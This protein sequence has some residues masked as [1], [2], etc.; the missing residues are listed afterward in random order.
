MG[1]AM[2]HYPLCAE[3]AEPIGWA[4]MQVIVPACAAVPCNAVCY[5][6]VGHPGYVALHRG[7]HMADTMVFFLVGQPSRYPDCHC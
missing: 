7:G 2:M 4:G 5:A 3:G 6:A 1:C